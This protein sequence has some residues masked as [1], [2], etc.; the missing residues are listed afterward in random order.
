MLPATELTT[1]LQELGPPGV[2]YSL[3]RLDGELQPLWAT[4]LAATV[5]M[6]G[7]RQRAFTAGRAC[8]RQALA[9]LGHGPVALAIGPGR[10][11]VWPA[12]IIGS[13]SHTDEIAIAAVARRAEIRSLGIDVE[14]AEPL[15]AELLDLVCR[16]DEQAALTACAPQPRAAAKLIFS[17]KESVYKC[18]WPVTGL[19]LE[20]HA[21]GIRIDPAHCRFTVYGEDP[22]IAATLGMVCGAYRRVAGLVLSCAWLDRAGTGQNS[23]R[24]T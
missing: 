8:A 15:E 11:P 24:Q 14:S 23:G 9:K 19:F 20:F 5:G 16:N 22:R 6:S 7:K 18:L 21:I 3:C 10:A 1:A 13:I 12:G 17:A 2:A 4:E